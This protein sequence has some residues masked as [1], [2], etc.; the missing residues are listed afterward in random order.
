VLRLFVDYLDKGLP[1]EYSELVEE[2]LTRCASCA[3]E[4][5]RYREIIHLVRQ[6]PLMSAPRRI[7][8]RLHQI[9]AEPSV[10]APPDDNGR[11]L[12]DRG[13]NQ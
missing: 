6:L 8:D 4:A 2:H 5:S 11:L 3:A 9:S 13:V 12:H 7:L 1:A 10:P